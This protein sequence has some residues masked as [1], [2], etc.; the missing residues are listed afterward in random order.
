MPF[1]EV[2]DSDQGFPG[3]G[4]FTV[5]F[6][7]GSQRI[8]G[9][10]PTTVPAT[11]GGPTRNWLRDTI[12]ITPHRLDPG[13]SRAT[14]LS[15][16]LFSGRVAKFRF[17][18][19]DQPWTVSGPSILAWIGD[20][21][22]PSKGPGL[23]ADGVAN[24]T[25]TLSAYLT[26]LSTNNRLNG[27]SWSSSGLSTN[28]L[29]SVSSPQPISDADPTRDRIN[30]VIRLT[31]TR[32][33]YRCTPTGELRFAPADSGNSY[34]FVQNP[35]VIF[36]SQGTVG[37]DGDL[38]G[39]RVTGSVEF[40]WSTFCAAGD[41]WS[42]TWSKSY[43]NADRLTRD[44][45]G[46]NADT[47]SIL[48][49][50]KNEELRNINIDDVVNN[51][52]RRR[53]RMAFDVDAHSLMRDLHAGDYV[54]V[55]IPELLIYDLDEHVN[56]GGEETHPLRVRTSLVTCPIRPEHGVYIIHNAS[57]TGGA[58]SVEDLTDFVIADDGP[59]HVEFDPPPTT[60]RIVRGSRWRKSHDS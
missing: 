7:P 5:R 9:A 13:A 47:T 54:W 20:D 36:V 56:Y 41:A 50:H 29:G 10:A 35:R 11:E 26:T 45:G 6:A 12:C 16:A 21:D 15:Q 43:L 49:G 34:A 2:F 18:L 40:D 48:L 57:G 53:D 39:Y 4:G 30:K 31:S 23:H 25:S 42:D 37:A 27:L 44:F 19:G 60:R 22:S 3:L 24:W 51:N 14:V 17:E 1:T 38:I 46:V 55:W 8:L 28:S 32:T 59:A 33:E 58:N 52:Y